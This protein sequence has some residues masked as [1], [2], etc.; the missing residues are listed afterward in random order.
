MSSRTRSL[1]KAPLGVVIAALFMWG[2]T[3][4]DG[5]E[6]D[7]PA[8]Q[9]VLGGELEIDAD[10]TPRILAQVEMVYTTHDKL[11]EYDSK[12]ATLNT[13]SILYSKINGAWVAHP[14]KNLQTSWWG[15]QSFLARNAKGEVQPLIWNLQ[16]LSLYASNGSGW[17]RTAASRIEDYRYNSSLLQGGLA[18]SNGRICLLGEDRWQTIMSSE[19]YVEVRQSNG[20]SFILDSV[21]THS[22]YYT[23]FTVGYMYPG[24]RYNMAIGH[25]YSNTADGVPELIAYRWSLD[26][27][28]PEPLRNHIARGNLVGPILSSRVL[29]EDRIY[30]ST[31]PDSLAEYAF[32]EEGLVA[33]RTLAA[34]RREDTSV[35]YP[36]RYYPILTAVDPNGCVHVIAQN[37]AETAPNY[38]HTSTCRE[39][40][41]AFTTP[42]PLKWGEAEVYLTSLKFAPDGTM[43]LL[44]SLRMTGKSIDGTMG[45]GSNRW[46][47]VAA[48][49]YLFV[50]RSGDGSEWEWEKVVGY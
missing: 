47:R 22:G 18:N 19:K 40:R 38:L 25:L 12:Y 23:S 45:G 27:A 10:G 31:N 6:Y 20:E 14:F 30:I 3:T 21:R 29:G 50:A 48:P 28:H 24:S 15:A 9:S 42:I 39:G 4:D 5:P 49:S 33:V 44:L 34:P 43:M 8:W 11:G 41:D 35:A 7:I 2:C 1:R 16:T 32:R 37:N 13:Q 17:R 26:P 36:N 46:D